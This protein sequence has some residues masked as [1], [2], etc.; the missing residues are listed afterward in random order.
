MD[1]KEW[2][3]I[4]KIEEEGEC[5]DYKKEVLKWLNEYYVEKDLSKKTVDDHMDGIL[6]IENKKSNYKIFLEHGFGFLKALVNICKENNLLDKFIPVFRISLTDKAKIKKHTINS[7]EDI[8]KDMS[9]R[10]PEICLYKKRNIVNN[11]IWEEYTYPLLDSYLNGIFGS[12]YY[13]EYSFFRDK[14]DIEDNWEYQR[15]ISIKY[16]ENGNNND[17]EKPLIISKL[18]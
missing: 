17:C 18:K 13:V 4:A 6:E 9:V 7:L 11:Y 10:P 5:M 16:N 2:L 3:D 15:M 12:N 14:D 8:I 1:R